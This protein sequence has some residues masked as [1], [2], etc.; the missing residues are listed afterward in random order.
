MP[1][2]YLCKQCGLNLTVEAEHLN[3][4]CPKCQITM[5]G[6]PVEAM[7]GKVSKVA[8][9]V[10]GGSTSGLLTGSLGTSSLTGSHLG[11]GQMQKLQMELLSREGELAELRKICTQLKT[12][13]EQLT[14]ELQSLHQQAEEFR[15]V[16]LQWQAYANEKEEELQT[17]KGGTPPP[18]NAG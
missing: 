1:I 10:H 16:A 3:P 15:N 7:G 5:E 9:P 14:S 12:E 13:L 17:L 11:T 2:R 4:I 8:N 6:T 18:E